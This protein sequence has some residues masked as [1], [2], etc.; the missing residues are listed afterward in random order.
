MSDTLKIEQR[1][2]GVVHHDYRNG[3]G[4]MLLEAG[5]TMVRNPEVRHRLLSTFAAVADS[6]PLGRS[7][8]FE[9]EKTIRFYDRSMP[10]TLASPN[11]MSEYP[12][13]SQ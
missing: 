7:P 6:I 2:Q 4:D 1:G 9:L 3:L 10:I 12:E 8:N 13:K 5:K 11:A